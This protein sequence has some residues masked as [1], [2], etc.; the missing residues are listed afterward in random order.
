[1][2]IYQADLDHER[3]SRVAEPPIAKTRR[4]SEESIRTELCDGPLLDSSSALRSED[5]ATITSRDELIQRIKRGESPTWRPNRHV[6]LLDQTLNS[7]VLTGY[8]A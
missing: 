1:M 3:L 8:A 2:P 6:S 5:E 7:F 4:L